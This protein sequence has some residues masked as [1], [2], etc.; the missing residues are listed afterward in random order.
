M[1][2]PN[3]TNFSRT[4][5]AFL[6]RSLKEVVD[7]WTRGSG[8]ATFNLTIQD[9]V[10]DPKLGFQLGRPS[11]PH[12]L[13]EQ[14][15]ELHQLHPHHVDIFHDHGGVQHQHPK[16]R[17]HKGPKQRE[18]DRARAAKHH[19]SCQPAAAAAPAVLLPFSGKL[20]PV[21]ATSS[22]VAVQAASPI[23]K[24]AVPAATPTPPA[25]HPPAAAG[26]KKDIPSNKPTQV[27]NT[28]KKKLFGKDPPAPHKQLPPDPGQ[29][30]NQ[31]NY[32]MKEEDLWT[33]LFTL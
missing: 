22:A 25:S 15:D 17:R 30:G 10:A 31:K 14:S 6:L 1:N 13:H 11:D 4:E 9:G 16:R 5:E 26:P 18:R 3:S 23:N 8:Q 29:S 19:A 32:K 7:V 2:Q 28:V 21:S 12:H 33:K 20:L 24:A 27:A